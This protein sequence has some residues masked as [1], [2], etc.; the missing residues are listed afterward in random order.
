M[1]HK[2]IKVKFATTITNAHADFDVDVVAA[3][4]PGYEDT[5]Q[6]PGCGPE[7]EVHRLTCEGAPFDVVDKKL[8]ER[9]DEECILAAGD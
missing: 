7:V 5:R 1:Y 8:T 3:V 4:T 6:E 9:I 2:P